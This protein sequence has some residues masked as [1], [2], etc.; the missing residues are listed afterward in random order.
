MASPF[1][2]NPFHTQLS[3]LDHTPVLCHDTSSGKQRCVALA[4]NDLPWAMRDVRTS[5]TLPNKH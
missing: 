2:R 4:L 1:F 3:H 5:R